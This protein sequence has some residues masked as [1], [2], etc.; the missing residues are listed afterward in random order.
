M[1]F[2]VTAMRPG[3]TKTA[4]FIFPGIAFPQKCRAAQAKT[5]PNV[6]GRASTTLMCIK[7]ADTLPSTMAWRLGSGGCEMSFVKRTLGANER[8]LFATGYHW[9]VWLGAAALTAPAAAVGLGGYPY[10]GMVLAYL[11]LGVVLLP[12]GLWSLGRV[13]STEIAVTNQ[14]FIRK[15]G[16]VSF[17]T[18]DID[19][20]N[21]ETVVVD[22]TV[23]GR[24]LG[25]GTVRVHGEGKNWIEAKMVEL[26]I[27]LRREIQRAREG[28]TAPPAAATHSV[29]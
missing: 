18:E 7:S 19:L 1:D 20:G 16:L 26:P 29:V 6:M 23:L 24:V 11:A 22:Q 9:I 3:S 8:L 5:A 25:Y 28:Q 15:S 10:T 14:R 2:S 12:F 4:A 27:R 17:D 13:V 21:I